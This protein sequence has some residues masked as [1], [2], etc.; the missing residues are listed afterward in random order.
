MNE[1]GYNVA[2]VGATGLVGET[3]IKILA[4]RKFPIAKLIPLAS[5][6]SEGKTVNFDGKNLKLQALDSFD[7][8]GMDFVFFSAGSVVSETYVPIAARCGAVVID[9]SSVF[10]YQPDIP[11]IIPEINPQDIEGFRER[12]I[13]ANPNCST[14]QMLM[15]IKPI[16]DDVGILKID[17][18]TYQSVSGMGRRAIKAL[19]GQTAKLMN[20]LNIDQDLFQKQMAFNIIP[21]I[22]ELQA[23]GYT[24]E[25]M[26]LVWETKKILAD[27]SIEVN[28]T[29]ARVP[30]FFGHSEALHI[31]TRDPIEAVRVRQLLEQAP[32]IQV[33]DSEEKLVS[34]TPALD[35]VGK[36]DVFVSRIRN[37]LHSDNSVNLW[38]V[39]D[40]IRKGAALNAVQIVEL[41]VKK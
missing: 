10:R 16:H 32:G 22:D 38:V 18:V 2:V 41:L 3:I 39:S 31:E 37:G 8:E 40:N 1:S 19:A 25:E 20:G 5:E 35:A 4:E 7:F 28:P 24:K 6:A 14:I 21:E 29:A 17:V 15:A 13:I 23:N 11:L 34:A 26:K 33:V 12:N 36:D 9:N 27:D 30:V